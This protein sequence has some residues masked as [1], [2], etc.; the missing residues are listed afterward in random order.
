[1]KS[2]MRASRRDPSWGVRDLEAVA[3]VAKKE[4]LE[5]EEV[6]AMPANNF[7]VVFRKG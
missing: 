3:A 4:G 7:T 1:M 5:I 2:S 6:V